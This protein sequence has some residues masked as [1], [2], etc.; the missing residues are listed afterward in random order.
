VDP[1]YTCFVCMYRQT[2]RL[3]TSLG[4]GCLCN[5]N[6]DDGGT[7]WEAPSSLATVGGDA[8]VGKK[9]IVV[10]FVN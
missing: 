6:Y 8:D 10:Q 3:C 2:V 4:V 1:H 7:Q 5:N 9:S